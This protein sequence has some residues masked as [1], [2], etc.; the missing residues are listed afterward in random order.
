MITF[1]NTLFLQNS[2]SGETRDTYEDNT[3]EERQGAEAT[4]ARRLEN[5][6]KLLEKEER[7][8]A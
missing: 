8:S 1:E 4:Q 7:E 3:S 5:E 6:I 2:S